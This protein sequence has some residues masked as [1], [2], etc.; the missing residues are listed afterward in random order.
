MSA[1][2]PLDASP[3]RAGLVLRAVEAGYGARAVLNDVSLEVRA[4]ELVGLIGPNGSGKTTVVRVATRGLRPWA[5]AV[6]VAGVDPYAVPNRTAARLV[7]VVPQ[8]LAPAFTFTVFEVVLMGRSPFLSSWSAGGSDDW[9]KA[10]AAMA[11][12]NVQHLADRPLDEL[13]GGERQRVVL[14][15]ALTQAASIL[16]LDEPTTHL[17]PRHMLAVMGVVR[18]LARRDGAAVLAVF[19]DLNLASAFCDRLYALDGGR[20]AAAGSPEEVIRPDVLRALYGVDADVSHAPRTGRPT[21]TFAPPPDAAPGTR[22]KV[23]VVGGAGTAASI[24][25]GLAEQGFDVS[26]GVLHAGDTD[27]EVGARLGLRVVSVPAFAPIDAA[28]AEECLAAMR[29]AWAVIVCD[30]PFGPGNVAN[31]RIALQAARDGVATQVIE[32]TPI[33][34][35]DFTGGEATALWQDLAARATVVPSAADA[36]A[37]VVADSGGD[38][39]A[40]HGRRR[41]R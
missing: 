25:R 32:G 14:A 15:Q 30:P 35:R 19:H 21:V 28:A 39:R 11:A 33:A 9:A 2:D 23:H 1:P 37:A 3:E 38:A 13:S 22:R 41:P 18:D 29:D 5:G 31:L 34:E 40:T 24:L 7:A 20:I 8:E 26:A 12:A 36:L 6:R 10:R 17:D 16:I 27:E 4:G